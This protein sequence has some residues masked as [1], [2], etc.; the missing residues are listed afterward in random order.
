MN[1]AFDDVTYIPGNV[2]MFSFIFSTGGTNPVKA[3]SAGS[4]EVSTF[5]VID[6]QA[7]IIDYRKFTDADPD[8]VFGKFIPDAS[9]LTASL[10][11]I[12]KIESSAV[13]VSYKFSITPKKDIP[14]NS[15]V[16]FTLPST[17]TISP[18]RSSITCRTNLSPT[19]SG[20]VT[21]STSTMPIVFT[22]TTL[23]TT[24]YTS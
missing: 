6:D 15:W 16:R 13:D 24:A 11:D 14:A 7:Y 5:R 4:F 9:E 20:Q 18:S 1:N 12:S 3:C 21:V 10:A 22:I 8:T 23:F 17:V 19:T 2:G